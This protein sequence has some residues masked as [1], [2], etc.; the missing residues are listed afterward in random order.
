MNYE[1]KI[2]NMSNYIIDFDATYIPFWL[3]KGCFKPL[4][5]YASCKTVD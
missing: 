4:R 1:K 2:K 3:L 5:N